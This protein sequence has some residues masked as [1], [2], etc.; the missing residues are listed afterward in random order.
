M[1]IGPYLSV[2]GAQ[3]ALRTLIS[4]MA[5]GL[6][7]LNVTSPGDGVRPTCSSV[8]PHETHAIPPRRLEGTEG[9]QVDHWI[10]S[11]AE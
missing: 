8:I 2:A 1:V 7:D 6:F 10:T 9:R 3:P 5:S 11:L 4:C